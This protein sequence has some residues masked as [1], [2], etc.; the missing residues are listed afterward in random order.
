MRDAYPNLDPV[1]L[2]A[3]KPSRTL[4]AMIA[5]GVN[6]PFASSCGRLFDAAAA[7]LGICFYRQGYE[8][9]AAARLEALAGAAS[10]DEPG[11]RSVLAQAEPGGLRFLDFALVW[12]A[13]F[14]DLAAGR[15]RAA[16]A[17]RFHN[18]VADAVARTARVLAS[19]QGVQ[20]V[21][22]SG[23]CFQNLLLLEGVAER[24]RATGLEVL[25]QAQ[26]PANDG[27]LALGQAAIAAAHIIGGGKEG[28][29]SCA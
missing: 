2:L 16:I 14:G 13:L 7:A 24:L 22:L 8:G 28:H 3:D 11:Y 9:D 1:R 26:A 29:M 23:G 18:G 10:A 6:A 19:E 4:D 15:S 20:T 17:R 27:G 5:G 25:S 12:Q 21:A